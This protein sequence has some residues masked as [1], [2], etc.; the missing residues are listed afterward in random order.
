MT[1]PFLRMEKY[2]QGRIK[3]NE[4]NKN[5]GDPTSQIKILK[6]KIQSRYFEEKISKSSIDKIKFHL[7]AFI[8]D[9]N[10]NTK[11]RLEHFEK[12]IYY[13]LQGYKDNISFSIALKEV[14]KKEKRK[15]RIYRFSK[16]LYSSIFILSAIFISLFLVYLFKPVIYI[17]LMGYLIFALITMV[18]VGWELT[19]F[20]TSK[21]NLLFT[22]WL[23]VYLNRENNKS[24]RALHSILQKIA[25][26]LKHI[27][28]LL[29][30]INENIIA[31]ITKQEANKKGV[32][33]YYTP[34]IISSFF[35]VLLENKLIKDPDDE[36][37]NI[38]R[39]IFSVFYMN[40]KDRSLG[41]YFNENN[42]KAGNVR[43][44]LYK[45]LEK[46]Q[47]QISN[48]INLLEKDKNKEE[49]KISQN[50]QDDVE[51]LYK[52]I[53]RS[54]FKLNI[55]EDHFKCL[56]EIFFTIVNKNERIAL[57]AEKYTVPFLRKVSKMLNTLIKNTI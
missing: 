37:I 17:K 10:V 51:Y 52:E 36:K 19:A 20:K 39:F 14:H 26:Y 41:I 47:Y 11:R 50:V 46:T 12:E 33:I 57:D 18:F 13:Q 15:S 49:I 40:R 42:E 27:V 5:L 55:R 16:V 28:T 4:E 53:M 31:L 8:G 1:N 23:E 43:K 9:S 44:R 2:R 56:M 7:R 21:M 3:E 6:R 24:N 22:E 32:L 29:L 54:N 35:F 30:K 48:N 38:Q 25:G 34:A 45:M